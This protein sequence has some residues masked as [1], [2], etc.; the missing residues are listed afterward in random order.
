MSYFGAAEE[1]ASAA[2][3]AAAVASAAA[4]EAALAGPPIMAE[5]ASSWGACVMFTGAP[6]AVVC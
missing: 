3:E 1:A 6:A 5:P 4:E 2:E